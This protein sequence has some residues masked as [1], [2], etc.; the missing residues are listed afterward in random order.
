MRMFI[1]AS[2]SEHLLVVVLLQLAIIIA[3]ARACGLLIRRIRQ[4][5]VVGEI[6]AGLIL[7]PSVLGKI[8]RWTWGDHRISLAIFDP[9]VSPIFT[10]LSQLGLILLLFLVGLEFDF[11]HLRTGHRKALAISAAGAVLPFGMGYALGPFVLPY[12]E[13]PVEVHGFSLFLGTAMAITAM[14]VLARMM[15]D[16]N[17][18]RTRLAAITISAAAV[19]DAVGWIVLAAVS[20]V[21]NAKYDP[22]G[23]LRMALLTLGFGAAMVLVVRPVL[24]RWARWA[25]A[26]GKGEIGLTSLAFLLIVIFLAAI[27]TSLIGIFAIFGAFIL[28]AALS[29]EH[30]FREAVS[31]RLRDF[32][33]VFF[34]PV[35]FTYTGL[36]TDV[37]T[38]DTRAL[39]LLAAAACAVAVAGKFGGCSIAARATGMTWRESLCVGSLMNTRGLMELIVIN[40]GLDLGVIPHSVYCM[41]VLMAVATTLMTAPL[42]FAFHKGT[43]LEAPMRG[44][45]PA[46]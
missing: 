20:A 42:L 46:P 28:G 41:L 24:G 12:L 35:F 45:M 7:G 37:G 13:T 14:P 21:V 34:L 29:G 9:A 31:R 19:N 3:V 10:I 2:T 4:P 1:L 33:M 16:F 27:A 6:A 43:E 36:R 32:V 30:Q 25:M 5:A 22:W 44:K 8:E 23:S 17:I 26:R 40:V 11:S 39:W 38:L 15:I 18:T